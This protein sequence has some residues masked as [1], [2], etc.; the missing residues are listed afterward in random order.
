MF[1][2]NEHLPT[3]IEVNG[4]EYEVDLT[5]D[6]VININEMLNDQELDDITQIL[7]GLQLLFK[8]VP[9]GTIQELTDIFY[10]TYNELIG[11]GKEEVQLDIKGNPMP[12]GPS[13][14]NGEPSYD[15]VQDAEL[16]F[17]SFFQFYGIDLHDEIGKMHYYKF[18]ALLNGL[19]E[20]TVFQKIVRIRTEP[21]PT[22]KGTSEQREEMK[23]LKK[24][25]ALKRK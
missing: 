16:I 23:K 15:L 19:G 2:L 10:H 3:S 6:N 25:Y 14:N 24:K 8:E 12:S 22:G 11:V 5:F 17:A 1:K 21:L 7:T 18:R 20:D 13:E 4:V 9:Q